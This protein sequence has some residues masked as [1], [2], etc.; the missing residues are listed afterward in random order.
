[1][2]TSESQTSCK[3][4]KHDTQF[5]CLPSVNEQ[6]K[7]VLKMDLPMVMYYVPPTR[8]SVNF[9]A[10]LPNEKII[11][12]SSKST[13]T[14]AM[15]EI[16]IKDNSMLSEQQIWMATDYFI[17]ECFEST[18][19][20]QILH[21]V[22]QSLVDDYKKVKAKFSG[23]SAF[24]SQNP[25]SND[26]IQSFITRDNKHIIVFNDRIGYNVY[27]MINDEWLFTDDF[28]RYVPTDGSCCKI[29]F[30]TFTDSVRSLFLND[31]MI[32]VSEG[33]CLSFYYIPTKDF[34]SLALV[35]QHQLKTPN[36]GYL[37]HGMC[38]IE[39]KHI[40]DKKIEMNHFSMKIL[41]LG[42]SRNINFF[43]SL[44]IVQVSISMPFYQTKAPAF[45]TESTYNHDD[46]KICDNDYNVRVQIVKE[47]R[48][49]GDKLM[50][51][52]QNNYITNIA[53]DNDYDD[54]LKTD[55][56]T[57]GCICL[58]NTFW[59][60][61]PIVLLF[62]GCGSLVNPPNENEN[63]N[64]YDSDNSGFDH[65]AKSYS[66]FALNLSK[67]ELRKVEDVCINI[68]CFL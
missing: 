6:Y 18:V 4:S 26:I 28:S 10:R 46:E 2:Y 30:D 56:E 66:L 15:H 12:A 19:M 67:F 37:Y 38:C 53:S 41:L 64:V 31:E 60:S 47:M 51:S 45:G 57:F 55:Y 65:D 50:K 14:N 3:E 17:C 13:K 20:L 5:S 16:L 59:T 48:V 8:Y 54:T 58:K 7:M 1:M 52:D 32:I 61:E 11:V 62:G 27:D 9:T 29:R 25:T 68:F 63:E 24:G 44:L 35:D 36:L 40:I 21:R 22:C 42:G 39:L 34:K 43:Q 23:Q 49:D 33:N